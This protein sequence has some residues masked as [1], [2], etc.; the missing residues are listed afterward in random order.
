M[1][2]MR[3][4]RLRADLKLPMRRGAWYRIQE[5]HS[6]ETI[7]EVNNA[8]LSVP[9]PF[10]QVVETPPRQWTVV[11]RPAGAVRIPE[12]WTRYL[13]CPSCRERVLI[14]HGPSVL[15]CPRC[16]GT[17]EVAWDTPYDFGL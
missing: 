8:S 6:L 1:A 11:P 5:V 7:L 3:W 9:S 4:A 14:E 12:R 2:G 17:F 15:R 16:H 13:V 10:L